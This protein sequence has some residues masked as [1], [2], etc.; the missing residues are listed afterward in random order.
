MLQ[1]L[2]EKAKELEAQLSQN[3]YLYDVH[4]ELV[5][6]YQKMADLNSMRAAY[7]RFHKYFPMTPVLWLNWIHDEIKIANSVEEKKN[8]FKLFDKAN[9]DYMCKNYNYIRL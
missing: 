2:E 4:V 6:L 9:E 1:E 5:A 3:M 8:V 7:K